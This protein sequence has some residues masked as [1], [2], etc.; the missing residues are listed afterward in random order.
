LTVIGNN[1][2]EP[3][4]LYS[5]LYSQPIPSELSSKLPP[6][7]TFILERLIK[8]SKAMGVYNEYSDQ[9]LIRLLAGN[10]QDAFEQLYERHWFQLYK[11]A[12]YL[13]RDIDA[14]KDIVQDIFIWLWENRATL[15]IN[16]V[17]AYLKAAVRFKV[18][19]YIRSGNIRESIFDELAKTPPNSLLPT[20]DEITELKELQRVIHEA[21]L[22]LPEKCREVY[23][24]SKEDGLSNRE[25]AERLGISVKTVEAQMTIA[26]KRLRSR[27]GFHLIYIIILYN[28]HS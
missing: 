19:N 14:S 26:L 7:F 17:K 25:I 8:S 10:D 28:I 24:M 16:N 13:L 9:E 12:L 2:H 23:L 27:I 11:S 18:A 3:E 20:G 22:Q 1:I 6:D 5:T 4:Y 21:I 15:S